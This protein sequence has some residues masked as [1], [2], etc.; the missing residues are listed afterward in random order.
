M[1][2]IFKCHF[3]NKIKRNKKF[4]LKFII[5][6]ICF[7]IIIN[8]I[9]NKFSISNNHHF[10]SNFNNIELKTPQNIKISITSM[11]YSFSYKFHL[12]KIEYNIAFYD[13]YHNL[14][15]PSDLTLYYNLHVF[16][17]AV[18]INNNITVKSVAYVQKNKYY[19]CIE[20]FN[21]YEKIKIGINI[22][23]KVKYY[24]Y[25]VINLFSDNLINYN[26]YSFNYNEEFDP[27]IILNNHFQLERI[28]NNIDE[29]NNLRLKEKPFLLK[30]SY[31]ILPNFSIKSNFAKKKEFWYYKNIYNNY[32]CFCKYSEINKCIYKK[33]PKKCKYNIYLNIIDN[34]NYLYK[35]TDFI[36]SDFSSP[37]TS[38]CESYLLFEK[39]IELNMNVHFISQREDIYEK[40]N[41]SKYSY[42]IPI[43]Y[44]STL[45]DGDFLEKYLKIFIKLKATISGAKIYSLNNLF[46]NIDYITYICLGHGITY[47]KDFLYIDYYS[48]KIYNK[49]I[50]PQSEKIISNAMKYGWVYEDIIKFGLPRWDVFHNKENNS[51]NIKNKSIFIMFTWRDLKKY[52][53]ISK[54]Y[55]TNILNLINN[56]ILGEIIE[57]KNITLYFTLHHIYIIN[58]LYLLANKIM[59]YFTNSQT[60]T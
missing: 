40:Y 13:L 2:N 27:F 47:L 29:G 46:Y 48:Y 45:I 10:N 53:K 8:N 4:Y 36:L 33:I 38:T 60:F 55:F 34:S 54:Y 9:N 26:D 25:F 44:G 16:C 43:I 20:Y 37:D 12:V 56:S 22:Y 58:Y 28:I 14:I 50:L 7:V 57:S 41:N 31:F 49:I 42:N 52:K 21:I 5:T 35:K 18:E 24:E 32:F 17:H 1:I 3:K 23:K 19:N 59:T 39:M 11:N 6:S 30:K 51:D 15:E